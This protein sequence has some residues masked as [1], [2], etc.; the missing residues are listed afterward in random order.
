[1]MDEASGELPLWG[2]GRV[3]WAASPDAMLTGGKLLKIICHTN[4]QRFNYYFNVTWVRAE[5]GSQPDPP[6]LP[7]LATSPTLN[8]HQHSPT[9]TQ[10]SDG[11][12]SFVKWGQGWAAEKCVLCSHIWWMLVSCVKDKTMCTCCSFYEWFKWNHVKR[13]LRH[14]SSLGG[15]SHSSKTSCLNHK[16]KCW[17]KSSLEKSVN[18]ISTYL[19]WSDVIRARLAVSCSSSAL[20]CVVIGSQHTGVPCKWAVLCHRYIKTMTCTFWVEQ[21]VSKF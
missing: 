19:W 11:Q 17:L 12:L 14:K 10:I 5:F 20:C 13:R 8:N 7:A 21:I 4:V 15:C 16:M 1:M 2:E 3:P 6:S 9:D 18:P